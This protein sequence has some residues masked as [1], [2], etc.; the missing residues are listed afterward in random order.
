[1]HSSVCD[2]RLLDPWHSQATLALAAIAQVRN[3]GRGGCGRIDE[4]RFRKQQSNAITSPLP[5]FRH[6]N[7]IPLAIHLASILGKEVDATY[8]RRTKRRARAHRSSD[9]SS[10][11]GRRVLQS[12]REVYW[13]G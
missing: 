10:L 9:C 3:Y 8:E 2:V 13:S 5:T 1:M 4:L 11:E 12:V 7:R 6:L